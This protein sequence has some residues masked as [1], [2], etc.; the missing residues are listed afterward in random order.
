MMEAVADNG[1]IL[2]AFDDLQ[3]LDPASRD[4]LFLVTRRLE[5][6]PTLIL[7]GARGGERE[8]ASEDGGRGWLLWQ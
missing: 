1:S 8:L 3:F 7:A 2:L 4:V 6:L 5:R